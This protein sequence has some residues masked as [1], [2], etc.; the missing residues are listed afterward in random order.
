MF[1][2]ENE[3]PQAIFL[4]FT[5]LY[6]SEEYFFDKILSQGGGNAP[7]GFA[8]GGIGPPWDKILSKKYASEI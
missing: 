2:L 6:I 4:K 5:N 3:P 7:S 8:K 1:L